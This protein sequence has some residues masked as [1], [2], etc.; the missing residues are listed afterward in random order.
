MK[1]NLTKDQEKSIGIYSIRN[2]INNKVYIGSTTQGFKKRLS[3]HLYDLNAN[4]HHS[5]YLQKSFN[6]HGTNNFEFLVLELC[7]IET[8]IEKEQYWIDK[9]ECFLDINGYNILQN[10]YNSKGYKHTEESLILISEISKR[11][12]PNPKSI[13]AMQIA[14][15]GRKRTREHSE[16]MSKRFSKPVIQLDLD[17]NF[18][19]KWN[20]C[21]EATFGLGLKTGDP[22]IA[23]C[24]R[25]ICKSY[26]NFM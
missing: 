4:I 6:K 7:K 10:A 14:N 21:T 8:I 23:A 17:G 11:R 13:K 22:N 26:K 15:T 19:K 12:K 5:N 3:K 24:T 1:I 16:I 18:I 25:G 20:S 9:T 2:I